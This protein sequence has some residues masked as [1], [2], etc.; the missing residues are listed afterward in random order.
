MSSP[1]EEIETVSEKNFDETK[2]G[3][4][5]MASVEKPSATS[6]GPSKGDEDDEEPEFPKGSAAEKLLSNVDE[7]ELKTGLSVAEAERRQQEFG[8]NEVEEVSESAWLKYFS[9]FLGL[10]P[11][12]M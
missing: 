12:L 5:E 4:V 9:R 3:E 10:V 2:A 1:E 7:D 8:F 6:N 11:L